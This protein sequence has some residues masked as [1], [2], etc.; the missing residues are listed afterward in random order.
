LSRFNV[1]GFSDGE[2]EFYSRQMV[3]DAIG[4]NGQRKLKNAKVCL[5]GVGG[6]GSPIAV[7]LASMG[8]GRLRLV[9]M[10]VVEASNLQRQLLY[11]VDAVGY[12]KVEAAAKRLRQ[13]NPY[14]EVEALP[15]A[16]T[17]VNAERLIE[18]ADVVVDGLDRMS[19]RYALNRACIETETPYVFGAAITE[20]GNASTIIPGE[21]PCLECFQ[22]GIADEEMQ[23]CSLVGVHPSIINVIAS[24]QVTE[25]VKIILGE[26]PSLA[27]KLL[28]C[29]LHDVSFHKVKVV[30]SDVCPVCGKGADRSPPALENRPVQ[31]ICGRNG[32]RVYIFTPD[33]HMD[34]DLLALNRQLESSGYDID[35]KA[36]QGTTFSKGKDLRAS[37]LKSGVTILEGVG[38]VEDAKELRSRLLSRSL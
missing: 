16:L 32:H 34:I 22:G 30:K 27:G 38:T 23:S 8:V 37:V 10:D 28:Y 1:A 13:L 19:P 9:D 31:E 21:T 12:P 5:A 11:G 24:I 20:V 7:Q 2:L 26:R 18:G 29:D 25:A 33:D 6:L 15:V 3:M 36:S 35:V 4:L 17:P 14:V